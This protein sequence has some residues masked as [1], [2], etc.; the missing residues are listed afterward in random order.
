MMKMKKKKLTELILGI[1]YIIIYKLNTKRIISLQLFSS[2]RKND[3][4]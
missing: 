2:R 1:A 4:M 3:L